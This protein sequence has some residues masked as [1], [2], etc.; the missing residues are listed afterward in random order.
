MYRSACSQ[1]KAIQWLSHQTGLGAL[2]GC[3]GELESEERKRKR[4]TGQERK[5]FKRSRSKVGVT[6]Q[7]EREIRR[8]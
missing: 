5:V 2:A 3:S 7:V 6:K 8:V 4:E 1:G